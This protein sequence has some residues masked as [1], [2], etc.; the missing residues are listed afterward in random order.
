MSHYTRLKTKIVD[1]SCLVSALGD[2]GFETVEVH[3]EPQQ[4]VGFRGDK[5]RDKGEV[6]IRKKFVGRASNDIG[7][8]RA[9]DGS[10]TA[11]ISGFDRSKYSESWLERLTGRYAYHAAKSRLADEGFDLVSEETET[12]GRIHLVLRRMV[13]TGQS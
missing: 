1:V 10:L 8:Q 2:M 5:R 9:P 7:F 11:I 12:D 3:D 13:S 6:I 4:L